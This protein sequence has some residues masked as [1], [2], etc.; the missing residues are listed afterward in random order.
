MLIYII[1]TLSLTV[2]RTRKVLTNV[3]P[4]MVHHETDERKHQAA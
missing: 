2:D 3:I 4:R 1:I